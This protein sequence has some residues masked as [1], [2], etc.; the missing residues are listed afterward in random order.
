MTSFLQVI[1]SPE[2]SNL[3]DDTKVES[4]I[5]KNQP[6]Q[7]DRDQYGVAPR[8]KRDLRACTWSSQE[9]HTAYIERQAS[10]IPQQLLVEVPTS[11][12]AET[13]LRLLP[14]S[15]YFRMLDPALSL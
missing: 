1:S 7:L 15:A 8:R 11:A 4:T 6:I 13:P 12:R 10:W 5:S 9:C 14:K 3:N 2:K